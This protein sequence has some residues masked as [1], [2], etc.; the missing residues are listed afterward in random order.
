MKYPKLLALS[1]ALCL[2]CGCSVMPFTTPE[3]QQ[4]AQQAAENARLELQEQ[5][6]PAQALKDSLKFRK[7]LANSQGDRKSVV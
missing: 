5:V 3:E 6:D 7:A 1:L 4:A 2:L